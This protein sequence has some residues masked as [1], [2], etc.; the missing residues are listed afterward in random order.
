MPAR[1]LADSP[2]P[3]IADLVVRDQHLVEG[4]RAVN[5]LE[6]GRA[7]EHALSMHQLAQLEAIVVDKPDQADFLAPFRKQIADRRHADSP[8]ADHHYPLG[9]RSQ[10]ADSA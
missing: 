8:R 4:R 10:V 9:R 6:V 7:S 1:E 5:A 2:E 3:L